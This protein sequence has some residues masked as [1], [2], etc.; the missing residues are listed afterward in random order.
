MPRRCSESE[1]GSGMS[2]DA[3]GPARLDGEPITHARAHPGALTF[4]VR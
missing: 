2:L 1:P 3:G 4:A